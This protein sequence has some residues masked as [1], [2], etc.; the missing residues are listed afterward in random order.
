MQSPAGGGGVVGVG[1]VVVGGGCR[2][3]GVVVGRRGVVV[4]GGVAAGPTPVTSPLP[5]SK[6]TSEQP[7]KF[8]WLSERTQRE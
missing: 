1:G 7:K 2:G 5:P 8:S 6:V 4:G 3:G